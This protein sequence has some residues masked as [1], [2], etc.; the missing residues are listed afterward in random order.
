MPTDDLTPEEEAELEH[1][2]EEIDEAKQRLEAESH[3]HDE[4]FIGHDDQG[5]GNPPA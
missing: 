3:D 2:D 4:T 5:E 1:L